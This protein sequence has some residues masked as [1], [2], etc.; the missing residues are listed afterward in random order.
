MRLNVKTLSKIAFVALVLPLLSCDIRNELKDMHKS[1]GNMEKNTE[2]MVEITDRMEKS[3]EKMGEDVSAMKEETKK[4]NESVNTMSEEVGDLRS[5]LQGV[6][7]KIGNV[8]TGIEEVYDGLRQGD[9]SNLRRLAF[10]AMVE[11]IAHEKKLSE[12]AMYIA[13]FEFYFWRDF[14]LDAN[15]KRREELIAGASQQFFKTVYEVYNYT[16]R[17]FP[18]ADP[19]ISDVLNKEASFNALAAVLHMDN[20]KQKENI[21]LM[22]TKGI[23]IEEVTFLKIIEQ[24]LALKS[25][26]ASNQM[27]V[28]AVPAYLKEVL[29]NEE[30]AIKLL[31]ARWQFLTVSAMDKSFQFKKVGAFRYIRS[32][33]NLMS[34]W[35][36]DFSKMNSVQIAD[37]HFFLQEAYKAREIL[38]SI[39]VAVTPDPVMAGFIKRMVVKNLNTLSGS[40]RKKAEKIVEYLEGFKS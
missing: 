20:P 27:E 29:I 1:T 12:A 24:G 11:A 3:T 2:K 28:A 14:G 13:A 36:L 8:N 31:Q 37:Q 9:S 5:D 39:N 17:V 30:V 34:R 22:A 35:E 40:N 32:A 10:K 33:W 6:Q 23:K 4:V 19:K 26:L 15:L 21:K 38:K 7:S 16:P 18:L 25:K